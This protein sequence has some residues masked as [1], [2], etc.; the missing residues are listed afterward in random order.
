MARAAILLNDDGERFMERYAPT[1]KD[2][3]PRD[4]VS[5][6]IYQEIR[7]GRGIGGKDY[8]YLDV[9]HLGRKVIE[10]KLPDITDFAR[11]YL[12]VE[13]LTE[14]VPIQPTAHYAMG[15]IPTDVLTRVTRDAA[16]TVVPGPLRRRRDGLRVASTARTGSAR[17]RWSICSSSGVAPGGRWPPTLGG[18]GRPGRPTTRRTPV[19]ARSSALRADATGENRVPRIRRELADV[20]MDNVGVYRDDDAADER[21]AQVAR[22]AR[23]LRA[24]SASRTRAR[25]STPTSLEARELGYLLDCAE[26]TVASRPGPQGEP[27]R[28]RPR[29]LPGARRRGLPEAHA[30][31]RTPRAD[32]R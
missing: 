27:R 28:P 17:T 10:E 6:S 32:P 24:R 9:R 2:L 29:G 13:P 16:G 4:M 12:G 8:V 25:C 23:A 15:G 20:M 31:H 3:A 5:R 26:T 22:P 19:R 30:G 7:A 14:P 1:M 21:R 18:V 11:I